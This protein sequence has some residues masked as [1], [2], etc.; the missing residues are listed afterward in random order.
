MILTAESKHLEKQMGD[1]MQTASIYYTVDG[2][3][4]IYH[5]VSGH[6]TTCGSS[7]EI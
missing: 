5:I 1:V 4:A 6:V 3:I 2:C 7:S